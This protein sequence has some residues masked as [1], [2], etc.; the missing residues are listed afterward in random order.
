MICALDT[1]TLIYFLEPK[2]ANQELC[3]RAKLLIDELDAQQ[4]QVLVPTIVVA[5]LLVPIDMNEHGK[6]LSALTR[7]FVMPAFDV[8]AASVADL[9]RRRLTV[10]E[11]AK[12][13]DRAIIKADV[14]IIATAHAAGATTFYSNDTT[15][16][17]IASLVMRAQG[18]PTH[19]E[20]MFVDEESRKGLPEDNSPSA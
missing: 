4:A 17:K 13:G 19:S 20:D 9:W 16:R 10:V 6:F 15:C 18:L 5:E 11:P 3:R 2:A 7:R 8:R 12:K 1:Q 14:M